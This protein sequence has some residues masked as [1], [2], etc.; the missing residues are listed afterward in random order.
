MWYCRLHRVNE[1][2]NGMPK[3][4][5]G[6][7]ASVSG[8]YRLQS[9]AFGRSNSYSSRKTTHGRSLS[10]STVIGFWTSCDVQL[11]PRCVLLGSH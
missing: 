2:E 9:G 5:D 3:M 10:I 1:N 11:R 4:Y 8:M 7:C 6:M